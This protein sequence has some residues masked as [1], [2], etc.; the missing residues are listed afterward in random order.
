MDGTFK[1]LCKPFI[2]LFSIHV[3]A[4]KSDEAIQLLLLFCLMTRRPKLDCVAISEDV[5]TSFFSNNKLERVI[6]DFK[7]AFEGF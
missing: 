6:L 1:L 7:A 5:T 4:R 3:F 2:Q